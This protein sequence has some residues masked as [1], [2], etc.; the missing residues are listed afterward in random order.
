[1]T[2]NDEVMGTRRL[3]EPSYFY[4]VEAGLSHNT[5]ANRSRQEHIAVYVNSEWQDF[6][7]STHRDN[8]S[9]HKRSGIWNLSKTGVGLARILARK[10]YETEPDPLN[11][12]NR[13]VLLLAEDCLM[14]VQMSEPQLLG[15]PD[16]HGTVLVREAIDRIRANLANPL[17]LEQI[18]G[19]LEISRR[20][21]TRLFRKRTGRSFAEFVRAERYREAARL[22]RD[23]G[24]SI[25][26]IAFQVGI[27]NSANFAT[28]FQREIGDTPSSYRAKSA[29]ARQQ[30]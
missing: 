3:I 6:L 19:E 29:L 25:Q 11:H 4:Y 15:H 22:L 2:I 5:R 1:M 9:Q 30:N 28:G 26:Q 16:E 18:A 27:D 24:W 14:K 12:S 10:Q 17:S 7:K 23:T 13:L 21:F 8:F 20:Q